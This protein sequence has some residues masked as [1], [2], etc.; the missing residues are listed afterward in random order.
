LKSVLRVVKNV[1][2]FFVTVVVGLVVGAALFTV[3]AVETIETDVKKRIERHRTP[4]GH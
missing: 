2:A 1:G 4:P 3:E